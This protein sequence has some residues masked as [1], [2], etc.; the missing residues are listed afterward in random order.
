VQCWAPRRFE[1]GQG[2][3]KFAAVRSAMLAGEEI[4][5]KNATFMDPPERVRMRTTIAADG[6][7]GGRV[8]VSAYPETSGG[9]TIWTG[10]CDVIPSADI[11]DASIGQSDVFFNH[12]V[13]D[14]FLFRDDVPT[15]TGHVAGY[16]AYNDWIVITKGGRLPWIPKTLQDK[17]AA[18]GARREKARSE[19]NSQ[20]AGRKDPDPATDAYFEKQ[21]SDYSRYRSSFSAAELAATAVWGDP[22]GERKKQLDATIRERGQLSVDE[23]KQVDEWGRQAG[24]LRRQAQVES[25]KNH[26]VTEAARLQAQANDLANKVRA[27]REGHQAKA[28]LEILAAR[29][30]YLLVNLK[31]GDN[32][33]AMGFKPDPT[34][35]DRKD[36]SRIQVITVAFFAKADRRKMT[37]RG[38]WMQKT[39]DT[40][41]FPALF[42]LLR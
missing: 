42:A 3:P 4:V 1:D 14:H 26:N 23:Q 38:I 13:R 30:D 21:S 25:A 24:T 15:L 36:P 39:Q 2:N 19:W 34:F 35:P 11:I 32:A 41:D 31:P 27:V 40:F 8:L 28:A 7:F 6:V 22:T 37:P 5:R 20:K 10:T 12:D 9:V 29:D 17:L 33:H 18:E 16:P